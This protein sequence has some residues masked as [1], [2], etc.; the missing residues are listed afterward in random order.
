MTARCTVAIGPGCPHL[1]LIARQDERVSGST[2]HCSSD[3]AGRVAC[4]STWHRSTPEQ[5]TALVGLVRDGGKVVSTTAFTA[6]PGDEARDVS[7][8]TVSVL[9]DLTELPALHAEAVA[10]RIEGKVI[11]QPA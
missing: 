3:S 1:Y 2:H 9:P 4:W 6:N 10:G 11:V 5:S 8:A 7:A